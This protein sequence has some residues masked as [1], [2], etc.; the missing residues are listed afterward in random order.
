MLAL[1]LKSIT[2]NMKLKL[3]LYLSFLF[4]IV[5]IS[6]NS[7]DVEIGKWGDNI[8][9][10]Q[11]TVTFDSNANQ[12]II[13]TQSK[14]WWVDLVALNGVYLDLKHLDLLNK[15]LIINNPQFTIE[16]INGDKLK[17]SVPKNITNNEKSI[18]ISLQSGNYFDRINIIQN[19]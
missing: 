17:I 13:T 19:K 11:K 8:K 14:G 7:D 6:C 2:L 10:S 5:I 18:F 1:I 16:R 4:T 15:D 9:L 12:V 3:A